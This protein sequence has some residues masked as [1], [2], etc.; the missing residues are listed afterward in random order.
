MNRTRNL[1]QLQSDTFDLCIIGGGASGAGCAL[2]AA[3]RGLKVA[4]IDQTDFAAETSSK[5]TKLIHGGVRYLEEA[6]MKLDL[7]QLRQVRHGLEERHI[8]LQIA[9]HLARPLAL[10]TPVFSWREGLYYTIGLKLYDLF[11]SG[12]DTL[13]KS[14]WLHKKTALELLP[15]LTRRIH[16][17]VLY[18]DGQLNDAR[19]C[20]ALV[21]SAHEAGAAVANHLKATGFERDATGKISGVSVADQLSDAAFTIRSKLVLNCTG[22][23]ADHLRKV[24]NPALE[25]R[26]RPSKGVHIMLP[27]S[28]MPGQDALLIPKT[29][30]GR[31]VFAIPF[32]G[33]ILLGTTDHEYPDPAVEPLL[34]SKEVDYLLETLQPYLDQPIDKSTLKAGFAG[35]RPLL[36]PSSDRVESGKASSKQL[37]RDH[38]V[39]FDQASGLLSLLGGKWTT[40]RLM[41]SDAI[42]AVC[43]LLNS[44]IRCQTESHLL[45]GAL[46]YQSDA[47]EALQ[48]Q[49]GFEPD[50][51]R[52]LMTYYG[53]EAPAVAAM[54]VANPY[55]S[56]RLHPGYSFICA[57]IIYAAQ[58]EMA[59]TIRDVLARRMRLE[60]MDWQA[61]CDAAPAVGQYLQEALGWSDAA[62]GE[63]VNTYQDLLKTIQMRAKKE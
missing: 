48:H 22:P 15:G 51:C 34:E 18:Y 49:F 3:L 40:Y 43:R 14:R 55:L 24:A 21:Q 60:I 54:T 1:Q 44:D 4:L 11:A 26:I 33:D 13:P 42:D 41:A 62:R 28:L 63:A 47:W 20:L 45:K 36:A 58:T 6:F 23:Y 9:P 8:L 37:L 30:D 27:S 59:C 50:I 46:G 61:A 39:E 2:D 16:S 7:G 52:H 19:F 17:A 25:N 56:H 29:K 35:L 53:M 57:E 10:I 32:E 38:E 31:V 12:R 5:S